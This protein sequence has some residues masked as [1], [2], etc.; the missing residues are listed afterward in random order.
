MC[1]N[2]YLAV[3]TGKRLIKTTMVNG[4]EGMESVDAELALE[5]REDNDIFRRMKAK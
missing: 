1:R 2:Q 5:G 3:E 4:I